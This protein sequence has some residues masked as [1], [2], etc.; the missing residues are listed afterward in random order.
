MSCR[1]VLCKSAVALNQSAIDR[2][3]R[4][5]G[6]TRK[7]E[8]GLQC[9]LSTCRGR[10]EA[11]CSVASRTALR[12]LVACPAVGGHFRRALP[13]GCFLFPSEGGGGGAA[14]AVRWGAGRGEGG[15]G[16]FGAAFG[17]AN[18]GA[19]REFGQPRG[20]LKEPVGPGQRYWCLL[21]ELLGFRGAPSHAASP[22]PPLRP[23]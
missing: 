15:R 17:A 1:A 4:C 10:R 2:A 19:V 12:R 3:L 5:G 9:L 22:P 20:V 18:I 23:P 16:G 21:G 6:E 7:W 14:A 13:A 11:R 8:W